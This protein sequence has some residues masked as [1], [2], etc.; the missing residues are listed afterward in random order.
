MGRGSPRAVARGRRGPVGPAGTVDMNSGGTVDTQVT[1]DYG[2]SL[3]LLL[4]RLGTVL[5]VGLRFQN[6]DGYA[7]LIVDP[8]SNGKGHATFGGRISISEGINS[9]Y[10]LIADNTYA[11]IDI[12]TD[13]SGVIF[14]LFSAHESYPASGS[15]RFGIFFCDVGSSVASASLVVD[16]GVSASTGEPTGTT[17]T[18]GEITV[19]ADVNKI[20]IENRKGSDRA[21]KWLILN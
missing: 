13:N 19:Y 20:H 5:G 8:K 3:P 7:D 16:I 10:A 18:D 2:G 12:D 9:G 4:K 17:G 1:M 15:A 14:I 6:D 11:T 21:F